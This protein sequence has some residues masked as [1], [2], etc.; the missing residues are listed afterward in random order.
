MTSRS[1]RVRDL[2]QRIRRIPIVTDGGSIHEMLHVLWLA[3]DPKEDYEGFELGADWFAQVADSTPEDLRQEI[4]F[5]AGDC[6]SWCALRGIVADAPGS[7][8]IDSVI[9]WLEEIDPSVIRRGLFGYACGPDQTD[10]AA[11]AND[12]DEE[13]LEGLLAEKPDLRPFFEWL[14]EG[15]GTELR[16]RVVA[17]MR[18]FREEVYAD[19]EKEFAGPTS[20]AAAAVAALAKG[21]EP[22]RVIERVTNGLDYRVPAE[23][24]RIVLIPSVVVRPWAVIDRFEDVL[25]V[26]FPVEEEYLTADADGPPPWIVRIYKALAD[27]KRLRI[28]RRVAAGPAT[29]D[30]LSEL[31]DLTKSTVHHHVG[32]LRAAGLVRVVIDPAT[33]S[34]TYSFR[35]TV[36]PGARQSLDEYLEILP[37]EPNEA[38]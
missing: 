29:L 1:P 6:G 31:L 10:L 27:E 15:E 20:H 3:F 37:P 4:E 24:T 25:A 7:H 23:I 32:L 11:R 35:E 16:S 22:E 19:F 34:K 5:L 36:I 14:A 26:V 18:R 38:S 2:T 8:D 12:G 17:T 21:A 9:D 33:G 30:E 13:A 28:L